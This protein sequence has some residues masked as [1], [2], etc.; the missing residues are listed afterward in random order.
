MFKKLKALFIIE[1]E[2][3]SAKKPV[4]GKSSEADQSSPRPGNTP[5]PAYNPD[6]P[7]SK[8]NEK[9]VNRLLGAIEDGNVEGFDYLEYKQALQNLSQVD[10]DEETKFK[11]AMAMAKTMGATPDSLLNAAQHYLGILQKEEQ[12]FMEAFQNQKAR[13][14]GQT[15]E[16]ISKLEAGLEQKKKKIEELTAQIEADKKKLEEVKKEVDAARLKVE[17]TKDGFYHAY[18]TV[19]RQ[20]EGD[21]DKMKKYLKG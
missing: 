4:S 20:I 2:G 7:K 11:S 6:A 13:Q 10:M 1:E 17:S 15:Q 3:T 21:V 12:K 5:R 8:A 16:K 18:H 19:S 9:F 14:V